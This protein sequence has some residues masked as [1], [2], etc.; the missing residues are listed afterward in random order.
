MIDIV[1][2]D[3]VP[4]DSQPQQL[5]PA[6]D[7][8]NGSTRSKAKISVVDKERNA[9][10]LVPRSLLSIYQSSASSFLPPSSLQVVS[11][12]REWMLGL[13]YPS[14]GLTGGSH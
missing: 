1:D 5:L 4:P 13:L 8:K 7:E 9:S 10:S 3:S 2:C 12:S 14:R 6:P 11:L